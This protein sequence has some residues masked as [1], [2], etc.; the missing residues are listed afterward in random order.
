MDPLAAIGRRR[1]CRARRCR[2]HHVSR[3]WHAAPR[4]FPGRGVAVRIMTIRVL[5]EIAVREAMRASS[6]TASR[7]PRCSA[8]VGI[9]SVVMLLAYGNGF[10][11]ALIRG[12]HGAFGD[13]VTSSW[14]AARRA[15]RR[16]RSARGQRIRVRFADARSR[17]ADSVREGVESGVGSR[18]CLVSWAGQAGCLTSPAGVAPALRI[19]AKP[20]S[21]G[22]RFIDAE[23]VRL[24]RRVVF[25]GSEVARKMFGNTPPVGQCGAHQRR[26]VRRRRRAAREG[27]AVELP[28]SRTRNPSSSR[29]TTAGQMWNTEYLDITRLSG[30]L[31]HARRPDDG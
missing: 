1:R 27:A 16:W 28:P 15:C 7:A 10:D 29:I 26:A 20:E 30:S 21:L 9:V 14:P 13:G 12:F 25:I 3:I 17:R 23:D 5:R 18:T 22:G 2:R 24:Q 31:A 4:S 6:A 19:D 8:S 11:E